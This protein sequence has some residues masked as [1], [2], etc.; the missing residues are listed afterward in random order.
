PSTPGSESIELTRRPG[1][2]HPPGVPAFSS[3]DS[4]RYPTVPPREGYRMWSA[5]YEA[6]IKED[7]DLRLLE[8]IGSVRWNGVERAV[9]LGCGTGRTGAWLQ[10][11]GVRLVDGV[12]LTPEML[13]RA[14][15]G[16]VYDRLVLAELSASGLESGRYG[17][18]TTVL[19][20]EHLE[21]LEP[22]YRESA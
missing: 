13:D 3:F 17:L 22:L 4:R 7:M 2:K 5:S 21:A 9:D 20:D 18:V 16:G 6:T 12:D 11:H 8:L 19:V 14:R 1:P 15:A 10:A